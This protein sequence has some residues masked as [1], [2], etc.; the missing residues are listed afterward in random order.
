MRI[1]LIGGSFDPIHSGHLAM[2]KAALKQDSIDECW[3][4]LSMSTPLKDRSMTSF[5]DRLEMMKV[6]IAPYRKMRVCEIEKNLPT[7]SYT[8]QTLKVLTQMYPTFSFSWYIGGDQA[9]QLDKWKDIEA[10]KELATFKV[11]QRDKMI[12]TQLAC[13]KM[14]LLPLSSTLVRQG[15]LIDTPRCVRRVIFEKG[16]YMEEM[17]AHRLSKKRAKHSMSVAILAKELALAHGIDEDLA[18]RAG[19]LHDICKEMNVEQAT[20]IMKHCF[21][22]LMSEHVNIWHGYLA[23]KYLVKLYGIRNKE[24]SNA[25]FHHV[26]GCSLNPLA[27]IVYIADKLDPSRDYDST[28][29]IELA[30]RDLKKAFKLVHEQQAKYLE[31]DQL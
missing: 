7:P 5:D 24:L 9:K 25:I 16:L 2:A 28:Y 26:K 27:M 29:E 22:H 3:F 15:R 20:G 10:C 12:D 23:S 1:G 4:V 18:Y 30:K 19:Q 11:F 8:I 21:P 17:I 13:I 6:A 14:E 31:G